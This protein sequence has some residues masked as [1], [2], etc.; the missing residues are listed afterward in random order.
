MPVDTGSFWGVGLPCTRVANSGCR[1]VGAEADVRLDV[2][3]E[4]MG[5]GYRLAGLNDPICP[6]SGEWV[7]DSTEVVFTR[8]VIRI[9]CCGVLV[10]GSVPILGEAEM[11]GPIFK[12]KKIPTVGDEGERNSL[13]G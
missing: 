12:F 11:R 7:E 9:A 13:R 1:G 4:D 6:G 10:D 3:T 2:G 5:S 8:F